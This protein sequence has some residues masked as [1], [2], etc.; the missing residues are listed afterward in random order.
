M[1]E[2]HNVQDGDGERAWAD[3]FFI[4]LRSIKEMH[5]LVKELKDRLMAYGIKETTAY[6]RVNWIDREKT[7]ILKIIIAGA[8]YPNY[9]TRS[10][11]NDVE[12]ERNIYHVLC[13]NDPC[14]TVYFTNFNTKHIGQ[15]YT[16]SIKD[17][18]KDVKIP[19]TNI[20]I[21]FQPG[22]EKVFVTFK[23]DAEDDVDI[24]SSRQLMVPG[25]V[26]PEVYKSVKMR[27]LSMRSTIRV[28]E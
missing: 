25:R 4:N 14:N 21:R 15:L 8:F 9:F 23:K 5:L 28:M 12:Q 7:I 2:Q 19:S 6:Q 27:Q 1:R 18:F 11:L 13:G 16:R 20:E 22:S 26:R 24:D 17:L 10:N 3:R